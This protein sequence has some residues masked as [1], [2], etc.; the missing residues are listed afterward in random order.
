[1]ILGYKIIWADIKVNESMAGFPVIDSLISNLE[2][3]SL[4]LII[5]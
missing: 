4:I 1:M 3:V 5:Q 2:I